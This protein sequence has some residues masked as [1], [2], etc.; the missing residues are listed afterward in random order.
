NNGTPDLF[1]N[2]STDPSL[3]SSV[4][5]HDNNFFKM[6]YDKNC[7]AGIGVYIYGLNS[8]P[9]EYLK[10]KLSYNLSTK[11]KYFYRYY[12]SARNGIEGINIPC[13]INKFGFILS[14]EDIYEP[15]NLIITKHNERYIGTPNA[16]F[17][18]INNWVKFSGC[19]KGNQE[20]FIIFGNFD[21][22]DSVKTNKECQEYFPNG[23]YR[24][25]DDIGI[26]EFDPLPD[27]ILLCENSSK[28]IG[29]KF[30]D[31][32]Y[33]WSTGATDSTIIIDKSGQYI[34]NVT[35]DDCILSDTVNVYAESDLASLLPKDTL[36]CEGEKIYFKIDFPCILSLNDTPIS[37]NFEINKEGS[38]QLKI[39]HQ[40]SEFIHR[41]ELKSEKCNCEFIFP[42]I[43]HPNASDDR[44]ALFNSTTNCKFDYII[45]TFRIYDRWGNQVFNE[46]NIQ[47]IEWDSTFNKR[48]LSSG[49]YTWQMAYEY[50]YRGTMIKR[51]KYGDVTIID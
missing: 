9:R 35:I 6:P 23:A 15:N 39:E 42:N 37:N 14:G 30:L 7:F 47:K 3:G 17:N 2:C 51:E 19:F 41:F 31:G 44:N 8:A 21:I 34:V 18:E 36:L 48:K 32:T 5:V 16:I 26:Y 28:I 46:S 4:P 27:T 45:K 22:Q 25:I 1:C 24:Y 38:Y 40:C 20:I 29:K 49:V 50:E 11:K 43:I 33:F 12:V 13:F 10:T